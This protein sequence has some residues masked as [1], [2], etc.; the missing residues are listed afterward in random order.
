MALTPQELVIEIM[1]ALTIEFNE[2]EN[3]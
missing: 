3:E 2:Y 1:R